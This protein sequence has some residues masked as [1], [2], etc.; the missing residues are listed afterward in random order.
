MTTQSTEPFTAEQVITDP[1]G[2]RFLLKIEGDV[3]VTRGPL[4]RFLDLAVQIRDEGLEIPAGLAAVLELEQRPTQ[5]AWR[6]LLHAHG[7]LLGILAPIAGVMADYNPGDD[8]VATL[9]KI[10][11]LLAPLGG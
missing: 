7:Q 2:A 1:N 9:G 3:G 4:G 5:E 6:A 8:A 10:V 11:D